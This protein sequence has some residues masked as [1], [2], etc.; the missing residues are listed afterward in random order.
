[1]VFE[2]SLLN[3]FHDD[4]VRD[5]GSFVILPWDTTPYRVKAWAIDVLLNGDAGHAT[6]SLGLPA[7]PEVSTGWSDWLAPDNGAAM[8]V[9][10]G[11]ALRFRFRIVPNG[12]E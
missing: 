10:S 2:G 7:R 6:F 12:Q 3:T 9:G 5:E 11:L 8:D 1:M 4:Q